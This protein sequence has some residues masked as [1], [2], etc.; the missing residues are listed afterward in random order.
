MLYITNEYLLLI[1]VRVNSA[2]T[3]RHFIFPEMK[4]R[5]RQWQK[6]R[7][8]PDDLY[9]TCVK[10][11]SLQLQ[12]KHDD[13]I[14]EMCVFKKRQGKEIVNLYQAVTGNGGKITLTGGTG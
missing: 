10:I 12:L 3:G 9:W 11:T 7:P 14:P 5:R 8:H 6:R 13:D 4:A 2:H 1:P